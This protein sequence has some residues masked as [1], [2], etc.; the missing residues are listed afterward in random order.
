MKILLLLLIPILLLSCEKEELC[1]DNTNACKECITFTY[2]QNGSVDVY[3]EFT[4]DP[5][6]IEKRKNVNFTD[7]IDGQPVIYVTKCYADDIKSKI[8]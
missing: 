4:C 2:Y 6:M 5:L 7:M 3:K 1:P 8:E